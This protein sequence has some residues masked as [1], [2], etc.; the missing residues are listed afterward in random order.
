MIMLLDWLRQLDETIFQCLNGWHCGYADSVMWLMSSKWAYVLMSIVFAIIVSQKGYKR[1]IYLVLALALTI[2]L[3]DQVASSI[4]KP[5]VCRLRPSHTEYLMAYVVNGYRG[6]M[7][8]FVSS[9]AANT[10]GVAML[11]SLLFR[12]KLF[13]TVI[14]LWAAIVSYSRIYLGVHFPGDILCG[15]IVGMTF[16][17]GVYRFLQVI[18]KKYKC[19]I[20]FSEKESKCMTISVIANIAVILI[21]AFLYKI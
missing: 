19:D 18:G 20:E 7:Y 10:F 13:C 5:L 15:A 11:M 2:T 21:V 1:G 3:S 9:H 14:F 8:G 4:I 16:A 12:R 6:G 17:W